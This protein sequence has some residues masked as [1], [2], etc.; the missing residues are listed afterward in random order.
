MPQLW[1][2]LECDQRALSE[3]FWQRTTKYRE[4]IEKLGFVG[5]GFSMLKNEF[6]LN[7]LVLDN[8]KI[9]YIHKNNTH[10]AL[11]VYHKTRIP[12]PVNKDKEET[13]VAFTTAFPIGSLSCSNARG[14]FEPNPDEKV[15]RIHTDDVVAL[16]ETFLNALKRKSEQPLAFSTPRQMQQLFDERVIKRFE[17]RVKRGLFVKMTDLEIEQ[18]RRRMPPPL[19]KAGN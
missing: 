4:A 9:T 12:E 15:V 16:Y 11:I 1:A 13:V 3:Q 19:P 18:A 7:R 10:I 2:D 5:C 6:N 14:G 17:N 8:G